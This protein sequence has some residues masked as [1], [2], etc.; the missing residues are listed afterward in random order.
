MERLGAKNVSFTANKSLKLGVKIMSNTTE[1]FKTVIAECRHIFVTKM[2]DYGSAW[3]VLRTSSLTDQ[4]YIKANRIRTIQLK[5]E[6]RVEEGV[7][8]EFIGII[9]YCIMAV[10]QLREGPGEDLN[11]PID[12]A[13]EFYNT[14]ADDAHNLMN[15]KNHDYGEAWRSMRI[16]S[17]TDLI[18]MKLLRIK[19][20]EDNDGKTLISEGL[21]AN[22]LDIL[23]YAVFA[24]ILLN[25]ETS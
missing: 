1:Q 15:N 6:S 12:R 20:I 16:S 8:P 18:L 11:M 25:E 2:K 9:N 17:M 13:A 10:I 4:I 21:E 5:G 14:V 19:Q 23:N 24:M 3:R 22:Y 7:R